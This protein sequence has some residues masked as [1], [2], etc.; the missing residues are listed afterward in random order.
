LHEV[1]EVVDFAAVRAAPSL[2]AFRADPQV[3][4]L[5][6]GG[7]RRHGLDAAAVRRA[8]EVVFAAL[9]AP[10]ALRGGRLLGGLCTAADE[11]REMEFLYPLPEPSHPRL[12]EAPAAGGLI[13]Q[14][15]FVRGFVDLL[16]ADEGLTYFADWKSDL[17]PDYG[18]PLRHH[19]AEH[20]EVQERLY[21]LALVKLL[22]IGDRAAYEARFGGLL[23][24]F[25]RGMRQGG[26]GTEGLVYR[27]PEWDEVRAFE[28]WLLRRGAEEV[29][30][31]EARP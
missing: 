6:L 29:A 2:G 9:R 22:G 8:Q 4:R 26:D 17:L 30:R 23:Y 1:L 10:V 3:S 18:P 28:A 15:G 14:R 16:F 7:A 11:V 31:V 12:G 21:V 24:C 25:V 13:A 19:V 5:F 20:Y 27:R